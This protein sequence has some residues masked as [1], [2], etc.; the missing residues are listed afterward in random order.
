MV[1]SNHLSEIT[2][3]WHEY[4]Q[5]SFKAEYCIEYFV[6]L[7]FFSLESCP[8]AFPLTTIDLGQFAF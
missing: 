2:G 4:V 7:S 6:N 8:Y 3:K 1:N 5:V